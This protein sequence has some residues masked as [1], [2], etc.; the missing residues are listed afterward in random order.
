M[1]KPENAYE[2]TQKLASIYYSAPLSSHQLFGLVQFLCPCL[3][4]CLVCSFCSCWWLSNVSREV[5]IVQIS[6]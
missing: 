4:L 2:A 6:R 3:R 1:L 5:Q